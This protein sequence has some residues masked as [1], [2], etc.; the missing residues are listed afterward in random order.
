MMISTRG[1]Y[2]LRVMVDLAEHQADG[3]IPMKDVAARQ[4]ISLKYMEKI[5]PVLAKNGIVAG[6]QGKGGGYRLS[7]TPEE[8]TLGQI[9]ELTEGSLAPVACLECG[10]QPCDRAGTCRTLPVW[11]GLDR[12]IRQYLDSVTLADLLSGPSSASPV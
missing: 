3:Y 1:R 10:A 11:T 6:I 2:A 9:L 7:R 4:G 12:V 5:L 8:Y